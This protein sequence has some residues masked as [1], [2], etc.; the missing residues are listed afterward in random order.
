M[1]C[2]GARRAHCAGV[3]SALP[4]G[5][6]QPRAGARELGGGTGEL[7]AGALKLALRASGA[8]LRLR[9]RVCLC[10]CQ[11]R[12]DPERGAFLSAGDLAA[13]ER[14]EQGEEEGGERD[15][16]DDAGSFAERAHA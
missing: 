9:L 8:P 6:G 14:G 16:R 10:L 11:A 7:R 1:V 13:D 2:S 5:A 15:E 3:A 12:V 4:V